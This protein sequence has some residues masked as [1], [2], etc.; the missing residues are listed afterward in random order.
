MAL[1]LVQ[2]SGAG[3]WGSATN[4]TGTGAVAVTWGTGRTSGNL[5]ILCV[6]SDTT[7]GVPTGFTSD[8]SQV[9][10]SGGYI[11]FR[12]ADN[13]A[14]DT[15][16]I[17]VSA[18]TCIA[19]AEYSGNDPVPSDVSTSAGAG[20]T[21]STT[22]FSTGTTGT[23]AQADELAVAVWGYSASQGRL[24]N[25]GGNYWSAQ[26]NSFV[27]VIDVGTT[28]ASGTNVGVCVAVKA[29]AATGTQTSSATP[30]A[31]G[32]RVG[33][34]ATYKASAGGAAGQPTGRRLGGFPGGRPTEIGHAGVQVYRA[35]PRDVE[36]WKHDHAVQ[37]KG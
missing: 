14:T 27:E 37:L 8:Q 36:R 13:S 29:L 2:G 31:G 32:G 23:T 33:L 9:N 7:V 30:V 24:A 15:P 10:D 34:I 3:A 4:G 25:G 1:T 17:S 11:F 12:I 18:S 26:T 22:A 21:A 19:W 20:D 16:S 35:M 28:K 5:I 6:N